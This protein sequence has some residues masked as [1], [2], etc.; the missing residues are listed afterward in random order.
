MALKYRVKNID[1]LLLT[2]YFSIETNEPGGNRGKGE[3]P[4]G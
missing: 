2:N 4:S 3:V 1:L